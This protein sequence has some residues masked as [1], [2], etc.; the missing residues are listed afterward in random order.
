[1][2]KTKVIIIESDVFIANRLSSLVK[3]LGYWVEEIYYNGEEF[4]KETDWK[5]D[6]AVVDFFLSK[7]VKGLEVSK[8]L[9]ER[10]KPYLFVTPNKENKALR[11]QFAQT[12]SKVTISH[13]LNKND[14]S[15]ALE[16]MS[17]K[18]PLRFKIRGPHGVKFLNMNEILFF[19]SDGSYIEI[20]TQD[21]TIVQRKLLKQIE[22][23]LP[24]NFIRIHR[25]YL[26]NK[27][28]V[29][30]QSTQYLVIRNEILPVSRT[31]RKLVS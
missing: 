30:Q 26:I 14:I 16:T 13:S 11:E 4:L 5:F 19:K 10:G 15:V 22:D 17:Q 29:K 8:Y 2:C 12:D 25:S 3:S 18:L 21:K 20:H 23:D 9:R 28:Y 1:M 7:K 27:N 6:M 24:S 31:Y